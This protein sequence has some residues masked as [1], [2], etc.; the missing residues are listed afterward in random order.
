MHFLHVVFQRLLHLIPVLIGISIITFV[1]M[2]LTP[3][4]PIRLLVG[5]RATPEVIAAVR[6]HY[7]LD[8]PAYQQ[9]FVYIVNVLQGD[10]GNSIPYQ[11]PVTELIV[12][13]LPPTIFLIIYVIC[14]T[15]PTT[16]FLAI[17]SAKNE[18]GL[19]DQ[20]ITQFTVLGLTIPVFW[21]GIMMARLFGVD[22][23]WFP[24]TGYGKDFVGHLH[25]LFLPAISTSI[26]LVPVLL[27]NLRVAI[28]EQMKSDYVTASRSK[29]LPEGYIFSH[30][31]LRNSI[32]PTLN[33]FGVMVAYLIGGSI[34]VETVYAVPGVGKLIINS[35]LG[36]D[37][38][39]VQGITLFYAMATISV[40]L[41]VDL[42]SALID[43]RV[44]L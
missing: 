31:I 36:R 23:G 2:Q 17:L 5:N 25:H 28:I 18:G 27:R 3:G 38:F 24:V 43:P 42:V 26:W 37:Y 22:L 29:G 41:I 34:V 4:D 44:E 14:I 20:I 13:F 12:N 30:H 39:V 32:L 35:I 16:V 7:G 8:L 9:Y 21:L 40:T 19:I 33:L 15:V 10:L 1:L 11:R 6:A